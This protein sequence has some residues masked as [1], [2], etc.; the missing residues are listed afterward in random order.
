[1]DGRDLKAP[2]PARLWLYHKPAGLVT[3]TS[4][5]QGRPTIF[6]ELPEDL[7]RVMSVGRLDITSEGLLLLTNDGGIKRKLELPSTGWLRRYRVRIKGR[8]SDETFAPLR[9]GLEIEGEKFQPMI[10]S[11]DRQQGRECLGPRSASAR[12]ATARCA[13]RWR[14]WG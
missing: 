9:Q 5:E 3:T 14:R 4:D 13:E 10:V 7:P 1:M 12:G 8:P 2:E 11:L 6:D